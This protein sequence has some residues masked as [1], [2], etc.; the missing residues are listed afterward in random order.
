MTASYRN[1]RSLQLMTKLYVRLLVKDANSKPILAS[2]YISC[3]IT[4]IVTDFCTQ[5]SKQL[6]IE[7]I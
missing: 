6:T 7:E 2:N 1:N 4:V 3:A 5:E